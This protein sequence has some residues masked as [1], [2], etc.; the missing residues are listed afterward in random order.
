MRRPI[1]VALIA[2]PAAAAAAPASAPPPA[3]AARVIEPGQPLCPTDVRMRTLRDGR[4]ARTEKL[5]ELPPGEL[6][7]TVWRSIDGCVEPVY[8]HEERR[9]L[10]R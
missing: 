1:L 9:R 4:S 2:F 3:A 10:R 7:H 6:V 8:V 5:G